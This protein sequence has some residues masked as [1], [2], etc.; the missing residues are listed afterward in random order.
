VVI[1][2]PTL[3]KKKVLHLETQ[4]RNIKSTV[5]KIPTFYKENITQENET[6]RVFKN[7]FKTGSIHVYKS[8]Q[9]KIGIF[10]KSTS[11]KKKRNIL[12]EVHTDKV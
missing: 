2:N 1:P 4:K 9:D 12:I 3:Q 10:L 6:T 11:L 5:H 7:C 8:C